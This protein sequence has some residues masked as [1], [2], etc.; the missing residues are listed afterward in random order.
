MSWEHGSAS[1]CSEK[2]GGF[3]LPGLAFGLWLLILILFAGCGG[4]P[5]GEVTAPPPIEETGEPVLDIYNWDTFIDPAILTGFEQQYGVRIQYDIIRTADESHDIVAADPAK[6]DVFIPA[7]YTVLRMRTEGLLAT[8]DRGSIPNFANIA[9]EFVNP[10]YDPG[11]RYCV[12]YLW[13]TG[14]IGYNADLTGRAITSWGD[15]FDP[16]F[17]GQVALLD[18]PRDAL[19]AALLHLGYSLNTTNVNEIH[20]AR[21]FLIEHIDQFAAFA[22]DTGQD[23]LRDRQVAIAQEWGGDMVQI[24]GDDPSLRYV[25]PAEGSIIWVNSM[26]IPRDAP[27][28]ALAEQFINYLLEPEVGAALANYTH[29]GSPNQAALQLVNPADR[30]NPVLYPPDD[31]R[32]HLFYQV[33]LG[34][35]IEAIYREAWDAV[36]AAQIE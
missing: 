9:P 28:K 36:K 16:A 27:D 23:L 2:W 19:G 14:G 25:I 30:G 3:R 35:D 8:L 29:Y 11:N 24:M 33:Y 6:Y 21:D 31:L 32:Q 34:A 1:W 13:G 20:E 5:P 10:S 17:R 18:D 4:A 26:C 7:E 12:P 22:P 15:L